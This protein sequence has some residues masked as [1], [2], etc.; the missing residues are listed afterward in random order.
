[1][2]K[3]M[4]AIIETKTLNKPVNLRLLNWIN[5]MDK[6]SKAIPTKEM[7]SFISPAL[8]FTPTIY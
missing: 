3:N 4:Y 7:I 2:I 5:K 6:M 1:M 8:I